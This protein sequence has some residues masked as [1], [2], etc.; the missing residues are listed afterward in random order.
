MIVS[1]SWLKNHLSTN[2]NIKQ[3]IER[4]TE[5]GLEV[6]SVKSPDSDLDNFIICKVVKSQKHPNADKLKICDVDIGKGN[7]T[8]VVC[9][10]S[11]AREGLF[12]VYAP[13]GAVIPKT[14]IIK[15]RVAQPTQ[16][17]EPQNKSSIIK[18]IKPISPLQNKQSEY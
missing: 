11:N 6:E 9:G 8:K 10:A 15:Q 12:T 18:P 13:P 16:E 3:V 1:L 7:L 17:K 14:K 2:A 4:L 5:I